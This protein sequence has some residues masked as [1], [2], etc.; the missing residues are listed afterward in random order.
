[1][2]DPAIL[3]CAAD[4][5]WLRRLA[6]RLVD[7][8]NGADDVAQEAALQAL[9]ASRSSRGWLAGVVR[10][11]AANRRRAEGR[12]ARHESLAATDEAQ[13]SAADTAARVE[14]QRKLAAAVLA[15][16]PPFR[17]VVLL[18]FYEGLARR[19]I[20]ARMQVP[21]ATVNAC[22]WSMLPADRARECRSRCGCTTVTFASRAS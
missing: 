2:H 22:A 15:L 3:A 6:R 9:R 5:E 16:E 12:R 21:I 1:M 4:S 8:T 10:N 13:P 17:D 11:L 18:R 7:D 20:A 19:E 14:E